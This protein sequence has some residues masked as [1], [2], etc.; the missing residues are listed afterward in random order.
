MPLAFRAL[1][2]PLTGACEADAPLKSTMSPDAL[3][4]SERHNTFTQKSQVVRVAEFFGFDVGDN[5]FDTEI[6]IITEPPGTLLPGQF[7]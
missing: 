5:L 2:T 7:G 4:P 1:L 6:R 3:T